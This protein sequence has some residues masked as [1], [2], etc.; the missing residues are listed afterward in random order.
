[1]TLQNYLNRYN[2]SHDIQPSTLEH[3]TWA[4]HSLQSFAGEVRLTEL[5]PELLN[6]WLL[7]LRDSGRS[8]FTVHSRRNS[9]LVIW[10][11]AWRDGLAPQPGEIRRVRLPDPA[12]EIWTIDEVRRLVEACS[13]LQRRFRGLRLNRADY[14]R[15]IIR[16]AYD[17]GLRQSDLHHVTTASVLSGDR[18]GILQ[19]KT[20]RSVVVRLNANTLVLVREFAREPPREFVW[21]R[22][23][24]RRGTFARTFRQVVSAAGLVGDFGRLRKTSGTEVE[25]LERGAGWL[26]L[27]HASPET[28]RRWYLNAERAYDV[29]RPLPPPL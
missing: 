16:A 14:F 24:R 8:P 19:Q 1:M 26:H 28:A 17:T 20:G 5:S 29:N 6:R 10:R 4:A 18:L 7:W 9:V 22:W 11:A 12:K 25:R 13:V 21:P 15:T 2:E 27:G 3:Y 23:S